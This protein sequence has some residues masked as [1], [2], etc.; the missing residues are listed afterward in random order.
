V[1]PKPVELHPRA[2]DEAADAYE[3]YTARNPHAAEAFMAEVDRAIERIAEAPAR[4]PVHLH[5]TRRFLLR[6]FPFALIYRE[7]PDTI[8]VLAVAHGRRRPGYWR[9]RGPR[10][11][12]L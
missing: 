9:R 5:G 11:P 4:W 1:P 3:W 8:L 12:R 6:R 2:T 7:N 10:D